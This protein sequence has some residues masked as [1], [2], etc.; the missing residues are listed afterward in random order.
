VDKKL[1]IS[2]D[3]DDKAFTS[4]IK[5][6]QDQMAQIQSGPALLRNQ[7]Q[8]SQKMQ[9]L[10]L[11]G[12]A[13]APSAR[14]ADR[15]QQKSKQQS[16]KMFEETRRKFDI[17]KKLQADLNKEQSVGVASE[18]RKLEIKEKLLDLAEKEKRATGELRAQV[19]RYNSE[20]QRQNKDFGGRLGLASAAITGIGA[21]IGAQGRQPIEVA[22]AAG[23][24]ATRLVGQ[25]LKEMADPSHQ[26]FLPERA[27]AI[28]AAKKAWKA[29]RIEDKAINVGATIAAAGGIAALAGIEALS[30]GTATPAVLAAGAG[31]AGMF[32]TSKQRAITAG[33]EEDYEKLSSSDLADLTQRSIKAQEEADPLKKLAAE[34]NAQNYQRN[35]DIQRGLGLSDQGFM[36]RQ[37]FLQRNMAPGGTMQFTEEQVTQQQQAIMA[38]GGSARAGREAGYGL[39]LQ[40]NLNL[41][42]APQ[43]LGAI[44]RTMGGGAETKEA[45]IRVIS[46]AFKQGLNDSE[47]VDLLR[48]FTQMTS[49]AISRSGAKSQ[50]DVE[51]ITSQMGKGMLETTG[52]G[53]EAAKT[54]Y[55]AYQKLSG[56]TSGP[57][58]VMQRAAMLRNPILKKLAGGQE[59][60]SLL[61]EKVKQIPQEQ[62][63]EDHPVVVEIARMTGASPSDVI[64]AVAGTVSAGASI[65]RTFTKNKALVDQ[66]RKTNP[67]ADIKEAP[68]NIQS[69][70]NMMSI[71]ATTQGVG[72][73]NDLT[74]GQ[75]IKSYGAQFLG[76]KGEGYGPSEAMKTT[77]KLG[78]QV[79]ANIATSQQV[80][81]DNFEKFKNSIVPAASSIDDL[82]RKLILLG[83]VAADVAAG[84]KPAGDVGKAAA[85]LGTQPQADSSSGG[86]G[87]SFM[88]RSGSY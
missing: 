17:I 87:S 36:G 16:D 5:R 42:N 50:G 6:M 67:N 76:A 4:A 8:L 40:K 20:N 62:L 26:A 64:G 34:Y 46:E 43:M 75:D 41:T 33:R 88:G 21:H 77:S 73:A 48:G 30:F 51:R 45:S 18:E 86:R 15:E 54:G 69:A 37:G 66:W 49:E 74:R 84:K 59:A 24:A 81:I 61:F 78:D 55:E 39:E 71:A 12:L 57:M 35:L 47:L 31:L 23:S 72:S 29:Q 80:F 22:E 58:S 28:D 83:Q 56:Q 9:Q 32:G 25:Q 38:A 60:G 82:T 3:L 79:N 70:F 13:G 44:S 85:S 7:Q 2:L 19:D 53:M 65:S 27:K 63:T 14:D 1:K 10:G 11:G 52:V 68:Q